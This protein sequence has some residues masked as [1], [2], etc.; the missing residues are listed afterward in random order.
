MENESIEKKRKST[1]HAKKRR[2][3]LK[4]TGDTIDKKLPLSGLSFAVTTLDIHGETHSNDD[5][6]YKAV[7]ALLTSLGAT[8]TGQVHKGITGVLCN[9]SA[10]RQ[11]TQRV[12][13]AVKRGVPLIRVG[14][15]NDCQKEG[16]RL[17]IGDYEL[18][19]HDL[20]ENN[21]VRNDGTQVVDTMTSKNGEEEETEE[22]PDSQWTEPVALGCCCV[23]HENGDDACPW[24]SDCDFKPVAQHEL[25]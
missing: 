21:S 13:K 9:A 2:K 1:E 24:C 25:V 5:Q 11:Q 19:A 17:T 16:K 7:A 18:T 15:L 6:S 14:F 10:V 12:R 4:I 8:M 3:R 23:C 22:I 20:P